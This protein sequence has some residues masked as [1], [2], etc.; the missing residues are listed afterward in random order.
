M[1]A[2]CACRDDPNEQVQLQVIKAL[3]TA[4]SSTTVKVQEQSLLAAIR[5][6]YHICLVSKNQVNKNSAKA[7]LKQMLNIIFQRMEKVQSELPQHV[8]QAAAAGAPSVAKPSATAPVEPEATEAPA[9]P[10][11]VAVK[12]MVKKIMKVARPPKSSESPVAAETVAANPFAPHMYDA[13]YAAM[14]YALA[15]APAPVTPVADEAS[16]DAEQ[17]FDEV[18]YEEE[19]E[20]MVEQT[21]AAAPPSTPAKP[22]GAAVPAQVASPP[23]ATPGQLQPGQFHPTSTSPDA[24]DLGVFA[25]QSHKDAFLIFRA[26]CRLTLAG[27]EDLASVG[28]A[29]ARPGSNQA[30]SGPGAGAQPAMLSDDALLANPIALQSKLLSMDLVLGLLET[31]GP[32]MRNGPRFI[33]ALKQYLCVGL[34]KNFVSTIPALSALSL[35]T[36]M[37][38]Q[39]GFKRHITAETEVFLSTVFMRM[40]TSPASS[41]EQKMNVLAAF[42][43]LSSDPSNI[44]EM[45]LNY[46]CS[47]GRQNIFE[48]SVRVLSQIAQNQQGI[49]HHT[50]GASNPE[51]A[52]IRN[53]AMAALASVMQ[54]VVVLGDAAAKQVAESEGRS[55]LGAAILDGSVGAPATVK[56]GDDKK[57]NDDGD[58]DTDAADIAAAAAASAGSQGGPA[59]VLSPL[60]S[61]GAPGQG[62]AQS[63]SAA[64]A[65]SYDEQK[66]R[67]ALLDKAVV[68]F[69]VKP[70]KGG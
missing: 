4:I 2:V 21:P 31:S 6:C 8:L 23:P 68:K 26:L 67:R 28:A 63:S 20:E 27:D 11:M 53:A 3:H 12:R 25:S 41:H 24:A 65:R 7:T 36:F 56:K 13:V 43:S 54:S 42:R 15:S 49:D 30:S 33:A 64:L 32:A 19:I 62:H 52:A 37:A 48:D 59:G 22:G 10:V 57:D 66:K 35:R 50:N 46:D 29:P 60:A 38:L 40:L 55:G 61:P 45:F 44:L 47:E 5:S 39:R 14:G 34:L 1:E 70:K 16:P 58:D 18:E 69:S 9:A 51:A 17:E